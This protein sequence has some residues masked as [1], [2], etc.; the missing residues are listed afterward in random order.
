MGLNSLFKNIY[1]GKRVLITGHTGFKGSW[2][3]IWLK[4]MGAEIVGYALEPYTERDNF[5]VTKL[6]DK[7][8]H[9]V[10]DV[11]DYQNLLHVFSKY[12]PEFVFH[13]A[14]Q[15][16]VRESYANPKKTYDVNI[17]GTV[18]VLECCRL[19]DSVRVIV[20]VTTD[21]CYENKEW[22]WGYRENDRL[23]GYD[24]YSS[25]KAGSEIVTQSYRNS[26]FHPERTNDHGKSLSSVRSGNVIG[27]GDW[28]TDR[29]LPDCVRA[30]E[31]NEP[32]TVRNP[33]AIRPWQHV[34]EPLSGYLLLA[35]KMAEEPKVY[36]DAWNFGP[37]EKS[38]KSVG[39]V[40]D[41]VVKNWG[42]G[43][44]ESHLDKIA[45]HE[46]HTLRLDITKALT[47]LGWKP[48]FD[49]EQVVS[50]T[51]NWYESYRKKDMYKFCEQQIQSYMGSID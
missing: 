26:F 14:A 23:G 25:S 3:S 21:K 2:L 30:L 8:S 27:G 45:P 13:L 36:C 39:E 47:L 11:R 19:T 43:S 1:N 37:Q 34:L 35:S 48:V 17:G 28:R 38:L 12:E 18:N 32:I 44:W 50:R 4:M 46:A 51:I 9:I 49:I 24:P 16:L 15:P 41:L 10:G 29:L 20:N 7:I 6:E 31:K 5:V 33:N 42:K 40:A 22:I